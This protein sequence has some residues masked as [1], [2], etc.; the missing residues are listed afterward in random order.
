MISV[1][2][3]PM[4]K[5]LAIATI[6]GIAVTVH[7]T[8]KEATMAQFTLSSPSFRNNQPMPA[9]HS[10]E[11]QDASP[12][13]KWEGAPA[14]T[15]SFAVI[16]DDPDAPGGSWVHWVIYNISG[17]VVELAEN[18]SKG[19]TVAWVAYE[20]ATYSAGAKQGMNDFGKVGYGGPCPPRGHGVHHYHFRLYALDTD[21][22]LTPRVTR[23]QLESAMKGH[24][25]A[26]AE[27][28]GTYQ[29]E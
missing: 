18:V 17:N 27:L 28:V 2:N 1:R 11:G 26:Q 3:E 5:I 14:G 13:L 8:E 6:L 29:R 25:L 23:K 19:D 7:A 10:C 21:L 4:S 9:K 12:A 20:I 22:N 24:I 15:K 16:A